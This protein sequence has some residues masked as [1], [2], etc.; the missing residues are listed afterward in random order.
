MSTYS[1]SSSLSSGS[2]NMLSSYDGDHYRSIMQPS[3]KN[4]ARNIDMTE[5]YVNDGNMGMSSSDDTLLEDDCD[6]EATAAKWRRHS[7]V[8]L[9][10][11]QP[12]VITSGQVVTEAKPPTK[13]KRPSPVDGTVAKSLI[14]AVVNKDQLKVIKDRRN[15]TKAKPPTKVKRSVMLVK[16]T[17]MKAELVESR[18]MSAGDIRQ[19]QQ[20]AA[21]KTQR[22]PVK[23][24]LGD[25]DQQKTTSIHKV[26][27]NNRIQPVPVEKPPRLS[28]EVQPIDPRKR[29]KTCNKKIN[30]AYGPKNAKPHVPVVGHVSS[31][32]INR[33][34]Y[35]RETDRNNCMMKHRLFNIKATF[36]IHFDRKNCLY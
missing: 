14:P 26:P 36:S 35:N 4:V 20:S 2:G 15:V 5:F 10:R 31:S 29:R 7:P 30:D 19:P 22:P 18:R 11:D 13:V 27:F 21:V 6:D 12:K 1:E 23:V 16:T 25:G 3:K 32:F 34:A 24:Q 9:N 8:I 28:D 33:Q 17:I